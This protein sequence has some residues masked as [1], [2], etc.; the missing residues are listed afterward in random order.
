MNESALDEVRVMAAIRRR[1]FFDPRSA[2]L[3]IARTEPAAVDCAVSHGSRYLDGRLRQGFLF[4]VFIGFVPILAGVFRLDSPPAGAR[5]FATATRPGFWLNFGDR[6][7]NA[8][9]D[10]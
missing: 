3:R 2:A 7:G 5:G 6:A 8:G 4:L 9:I 10:P 1:H